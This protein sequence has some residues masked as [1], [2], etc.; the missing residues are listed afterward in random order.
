[1]G[2]GNGCKRI[3]R[4]SSIK[5]DDSGSFSLNFPTMQ[6]QPFTSWELLGSTKSNNS[7]IVNNVTVGKIHIKMQPKKDDALSNFNSDQSIDWIYLTLLKCLRQE[8]V[9]HNINFIHISYAG[10]WTKSFETACL[11]EMES[12]EHFKYIFKNYIKPRHNSIFLFQLFHSNAPS[13][14]RVMVHKPVSR[15]EWPEDMVP[16]GFNI[17]VVDKDKCNPFQDQVFASVIHVYTL[18]GR[19]WSRYMIPDSINT[20]NVS[21]TS[22]KIPD[23][24]I[25][26][27][28]KARHYPY[29][30][31]KKS[32]T[33]D[34]KK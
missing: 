14:K 27:K 3:W 16:D 18:Y 32:S 21:P 34:D 8:Y 12:V 31:P 4:H 22:F 28:A 13:S 1:M 29:R 20:K 6:H 11:L 9:D 5:G 19:Q 23:T 15:E 25:W 26:K 33:N 24:E 10:C 2:H 30:I 7:S 17:V